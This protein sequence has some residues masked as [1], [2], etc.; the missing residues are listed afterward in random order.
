MLGLVEL[1]NAAQERRRKPAGDPGKQDNE[2]HDAGRD[3]RIPQRQAH[4]AYRD[5]HRIER[6]D[7]VADGRIGIRYRFPDPLCRL[8]RIFFGR[9]FGKVPGLLG[10]RRRTF[11]GGGI[12]VGRQ[13]RGSCGRHCA[14]VFMRSKPC[15]RSAIK[16]SRSSSPMDSRTA[17]RSP[18]SHPSRGHAIS[19]RIGCTSNGKA[20]DSYPPQL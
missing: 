20:R 13:G 15:A 10:R 14:P 17:N 2:Q 8:D 12:R 19:E 6:I 4:G 3:N 18:S 7:D 16:S 1:R 9:V 5:R 11:V